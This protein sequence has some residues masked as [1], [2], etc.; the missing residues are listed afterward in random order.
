MS[1]SIDENS[2]VLKGSRPHVHVHVQRHD[3]TCKVK[4]AG[5][6]ALYIYLDAQLREILPGANAGEREKERERERERE[7]NT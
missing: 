2:I 3:I 1:T 6:C 7:L 4:R 5:L